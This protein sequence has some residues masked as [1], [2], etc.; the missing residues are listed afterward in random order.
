M[1][2]DEANRKT[3]F[4]LLAENQETNIKDYVLG[5]DL[6]K[7]YTQ[8]NGT[9]RSGLLGRRGSHLTTMSSPSRVE[10]RLRSFQNY[11]TIVAAL[12]NSKRLSTTTQK[13]LLSNSVDCC[14]V[15]ISYWFQEDNYQHLFYQG[16]ML[17]LVLSRWL[18]TRSDINLNQRGLILIISLATAADT[19]DFFS[20]LGMDF[21][22]RNSYLLFS[23]LLILTLSLIQFVF[24]SIE[25]SFSYNSSKSPVEQNEEF[26]EENQEDA[27]NQEKN[28]KFPFIHK[29]YE[30]I[31]KHLKGDS[32]VQRDTK[33][34]YNF[35]RG[36]SRMEN[37]STRQG[38]LCYICCC[39]FQQQDPLFFILLA[40]LFLHDGS[41][42]TF[43]VFAVTKLGLETILNQNPLMVF[44]MVKNVLIILTQIH[45]VYTTTNEKRQKRLMENYRDYMQH[46]INRNFMSPTTQIA[47]AATGGQIPLVPGYANFNQQ[48]YPPNSP[49][50]FAQIYNENAAPMNHN[51]R[52]LN[53]SISSLSGNTGF[54][55]DK[56]CKGQTETGE[57]GF[58]NG[59]G[60]QYQQQNGEH[61]NYVLKQQQYDANI[62]LCQNVQNQ[63]NLSTP[64]NPF[65][66]KVGKALYGLPFMSRSK[67]S[68]SGQETATNMSNGA[69]FVSTFRNNS[70]N[71]SNKNLKASKI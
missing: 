58:N 59:F 68:I 56:N 13:N 65:V 11:S 19:L 4:Q 62:M 45:K 17:V 8:T 34:Q 31:K 64:N 54:F 23:V 1:C 53:R 63:G 14:D 10:R 43:R 27:K 71:Q 18:I 6:V 3:R 48:L 29:H 28:E 51:N 36:G 46:E 21:V 32:T 66:N 37:N 15:K 33:N 44:F 49:Y 2:I 5:L 7:G 50:R 60:Y 35:E 26:F 41:Y 70:F 69:G 52:G 61:G 57:S 47:A 39:C 12:R 25:E 55:G 40:G 67:T 30:F 24:L 38:W 16:L 20:Y 9:A 42:L 22:Y